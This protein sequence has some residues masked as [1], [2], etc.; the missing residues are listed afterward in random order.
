MSASSQP[1]TLLIGECD[2]TQFRRA[3]VDAGDCGSL[4]DSPQ[5]HH[6]PSIQDAVSLINRGEVVPEFVIVYQSIP[7]EFLGAEIDQLIGLLPLSRFVVAFS[8]WCESIG[9]TEQRWPSAWSVPVAHAAARIRSELQQ[10]ASDA[11]PLPA[12]ASRDEAFS[13]LAAGGLSSGRN[14]NRD[15]SAKVYCDD[16]P[17]RECFEGILKSL[18]FKIEAESPDV[19]VLVAAFIDQSQLAWVEARSSEALVYWGFAQDAPQPQFIVASDMATPGDVTAL[20]AAGATAVVSQLRFAEDL[21][22]LLSK[23]VAC[24]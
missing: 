6:A 9:R 5:T 14:P 2:G 15:L 21:V 1:V 18:G 23:T 11:P 8:P 16:R 7:D 4:W 12:T 13:T 3:V 17:L 20:K 19:S 10:W 22:D 24:D